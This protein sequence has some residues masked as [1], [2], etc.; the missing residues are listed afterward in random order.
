MKNIFLS[1]IVIVVL[2]S[3][4]KDTKGSM[5]VSGEVKGLKK[6]TLYLQKMK[7]TLL[8]SVDSMT[9]DGI[10]LFSL[11]DELESPEIYY[12]NLDKREDKT[13][14]FFGDKGTIEIRTKL[15][16]FIIASV[17]TGQKNQQLLE[18]YN[19]M[20]SQYGNKNLEYIKAEFDSKKAN[21][22]ITLD[23]IQK[24]LTSLTKSKYRYTVNFAMTNS[25]SEIAPYLALTELYNANVIWLDSINNS[26]TKE[27]KTSKYGKKLASFISEIKSKE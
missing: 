6:G 13:I 1:L 7:D 11:S 25:N 22:S 8:V 19:D 26:L 23:S 10:N 20:M 24:R 15:D 2:V 3:C 16:K 18:E 4:S 27:V 12:L 9:L 5:V 17:V 14:P 21:D